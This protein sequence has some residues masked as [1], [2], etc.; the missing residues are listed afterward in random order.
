MAIRLDASFETASSAIGT[1]A[2]GTFAVTKIGSTA[3]ASN[4]F[5]RLTCHVLN[6]VHRRRLRRRGKRRRFLAV[7]FLVR[8]ARCRGLKIQAAGPRHRVVPLRPPAC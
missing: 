5:A 3:T 2:A 7:S 8:R 6:F 1:F 4:A